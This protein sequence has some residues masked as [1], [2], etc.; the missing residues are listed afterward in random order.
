MNRLDFSN[1]NSQ[2]LIDAATVYRRSTVQIK[3]GV[4]GSII[5]ATV[6]LAGKRVSFGSPATQRRINI[7]SFII[8]AT[9]ICS[10]IW[11][12]Y[13]LSQFRSYRP[14]LTFDK[15]AYRMIPL[16]H[17]Y[18][19]R[20]KKDLN[21]NKKMKHDT[22]MQNFLE[23]TPK[24][25]WVI[26]AEEWLHT[27]RAFL[28]RRVEL[29]LSHPGEI[30][31]KVL[32]AQDEETG[33]IGF[34]DF[35]EKAKHDNNSRIE[36]L[37]D[38]QGGV[39]GLINYLHDSNIDDN[40]KLPPDAP[41]VVFIGDLVDGSVFGYEVWYVVMRLYLTNPNKVTILK[42]NHD[43]NDMSNIDEY[44]AK[45]GTVKEKTY[46]ESRKINS[47]VI[48]LLGSTLPAIYVADHKG[49]LCCFSH[50]IDVKASPNLASA[51]TFSDIP[52]RDATSLVLNRDDLDLEEG[53]LEGLKKPATVPGLTYGMV[54]SLVHF[55][56]QSNFIK[57]NFD[58]ATAHGDGCNFASEHI[59]SLW[60]NHLNGGANVQHWTVG[61]HDEPTHGDNQG[62]A[63]GSLGEG[64]TLT[65]IDGS[66]DDLQTTYEM[67][68]GTYLATE[69]TWE[70]LPV[71]RIH[72]YEGY[73]FY[74]KG[75]PLLD[76]ALIKKFKASFNMIK[77]TLQDKGIRTHQ[78]LSSG[79]RHPQTE[80]LFCAYNIN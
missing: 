58:L 28:N 59:V 34:Y 18:F 62:I 5:S 74:K 46:S 67:P 63:R 80:L 77:K 41:H 57:N 17:Q 39:G 79:I 11:G 51:N 48:N 1:F 66:F 76:P 4:I 45:Y 52:Y 36:V 72:D 71:Q 61:H 26:S 60:V 8:L 65:I 15:L 14:K 23:K 22:A 13:R 43:L 9:S 73:Y 64:K 2:F 78:N 16:Y 70:T 32:N 55:K 7:F 54:K 24:D 33:R 56:N 40:F 35:T 25:S 21:N 47:A 3:T 6:L 37:G 10:F 12:K 49:T 42:G 31:D 69:N 19:A 38:I 29:L 68:V 27:A 30:L 53:A 50:S 44:R 75:D 20:I